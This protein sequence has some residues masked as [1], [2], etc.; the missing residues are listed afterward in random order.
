M[1]SKALAIVAAVW[2]MASAACSVGNEVPPTAKPPAR[3][4]PTQAAEIASPQPTIEPTTTLLFTGDIIPARCTDTA[5]TALGGDWTLPF[6]ALQPQLAAADI[7]IA[8]LDS[9]ISDA[10]VPTGCIET[11]SLGGVAAV[12]DGLKYAGFD[13][14]SH[15]ANHIKDC[16][17]A[18][19]GDQALFDTIANLRAVGIQPVGSGSNLFEARA[20]VVVERNGIYFAFLAYDDVAT[21]YHAT[22]EYPGTAPLDPTTIAEDITNAKKVADVVIVLPQWGIE[23]QTEPS[24][25]QREVARAAVAAGAD[26]IAGNHPHWPQSYETMA[27]PSGEDVFVAYAMGNFVFDQDWSLETQQGLM[28]EVMLTGTEVTGI[29]FHPIHIYDNYQPRLAEPAEAAEI[30]GRI[31]AVATALAVPA[32][33]DPAPSSRAQHR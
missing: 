17:A 8:T 13:V 3:P 16:G 15:A 14:I 25:R 28:L 10:V 12:A 11:F 27:G 9:T 24:E 6:Q 4:A 18:N 21:W 31:D 23:Y 32:P 26:L 5:V 1:L 19:C 30:I 2:V 7:T 29:K 20:P 22:G 33:T